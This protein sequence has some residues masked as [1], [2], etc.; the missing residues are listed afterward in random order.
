MSVVLKV[1]DTVTAD[2]VAGVAEVV[3]AA[4]SYCW[5]ARIVTDAPVYVLIDHEDE[6]PEATDADFP[7][8][9][10]Q[11]TFLAVG[12]GEEISVVSEDVANVWISEVKCS[13]Y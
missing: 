5:T 10:Y 11:E 3:V 2:L 4:K 8:L 12:K 6:A 9:E 7:I 1:F 13:A